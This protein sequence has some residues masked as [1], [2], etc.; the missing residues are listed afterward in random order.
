MGL[1]HLFL[2]VLCL[3]VLAGGCRAA[4]HA[5]SKG[6]NRDIVAGGAEV[7]LLAEE[8]KFTEGPA[9]DKKGNVYFTDQPNDRIMIWAVGGKLS[10]FMSPCGR[11][12]GLYF[13]KKGNL[14]ACAD[15]KNELWRIDMK[16]GHKVLVSGY[17][18]KLLNAPN[19]LWITPKGGIY[20]TDPFYKRNYWKRG[21]MEQDG[22]CVYFL[23]KE[24]A[25]LVRVADDLKQPNGIIGT[26]DGKK[27][28]VAD[29]GAGRTYVYDTDKDGTLSN[30]KLFCE[31]GS[32]GMTIDNEGNVYLT[33]RGVSVYNK[34]GVKIKQIDIDEGWMANVTFGGKDRRTLFITAKDSLYSLKMRVK[35]Y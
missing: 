12:N 22:Q 11:S 33:G 21:P 19:D 34:A 9:A 8:F 27:L 31:Q 2:M 18:G 1:R 16:K 32:D 28:Y 4:E 30:K 24:G 15:E 35:G 7:V 10:T 29:I 6:N 20:F 14:I 26:P 25:K 17:K 23:A 13:D 5:E 3:V